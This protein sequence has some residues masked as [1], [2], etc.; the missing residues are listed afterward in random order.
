MSYDREKYAQ[1]YVNALGDIVS[2][3]DGGKFIDQLTELNEYVKDHEELVLAFASRRL[4]TD[5]EKSLINALCNGYDSNVEKFLQVL[6]QNG[7]IMILNR[8][9]DKFVDFQNERLKLMAFKVTVTYKLDNAQQQKLEETLKNKFDL[10]EVQINYQV[11]KDLI[12]GIIIESNT[13]LID[14]SIRTRLDRIKESLFH[15]KINDKGLEA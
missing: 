5:V 12:G 6:V 3:K 4:P 8:V 1:A 11:D 7:H 15:I 2:V 13:Y 14:D 10:N 9:R